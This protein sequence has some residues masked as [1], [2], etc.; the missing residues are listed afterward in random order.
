MR[1]TKLE[2][3]LLESPVVVAMAVLLAVPTALLLLVGFSEAG[4]FEVTVGG[5]NTSAFSS[6]FESHALRVQFVRSLEIGLLTTFFSVTLGFGLAYWAVFRAKR[7]NLAFALIL[8]ALVA[9]YIAR[10]YAWRTVLGSEGIVSS[11]VAGL[12]FTDANQPVL[13]F[14]PA[15]VVI[16]QTNVFLPLSALVLAS[17]MA[18]V[19]PTWLEAARIQGYSATAALF[20]VMLP[21]VG[22]ALLTAVC[23]TFILATGDYIAPQLLGGSDGTTLGS[24]IAAQFQVV[25]DY[26][27]GSA[28]SLIMLLEFILFFAVTWAVSRRCGLLPRT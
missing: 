20:T 6:I 4:P 12:G 28:I 9:S 15:A 7:R 24:V 18:R 23:F 11:V 8:V 25:G 2:A 14:T 13:L 1:P 5:W 10:I 27:T 3:F 16:A 22:R 26:K 21:I 19:R 17:G